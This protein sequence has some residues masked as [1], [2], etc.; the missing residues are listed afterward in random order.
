MQRARTSNPAAG[1]FNPYSAG[2]CSGSDWSD[3]K[4]DR[5]H[6]VSIL[7][8]LE[9]ALEVSYQYDIATQQLRFNPYSAGNCSGSFPFTKA[10]QHFTRVSILILLE[11]ALE[12]FGEKL[13]RFASACFNPYSA[14]NC[15]GSSVNQMGY[16]EG[17]GCFNPYSA[18]NCSGSRQFRDF[19]KAQFEFQSLFCWKLL[20][21]CRASLR[22]Y[23]Y[24]KVSILILLEIALEAKV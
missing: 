1:S 21:K 8:L 23:H 10:F 7:I 24:S 22:L 2:N 20:W 12:V 6:F 14:G 16:E 3:K 19:Q 18:G 4:R 13:D 11:I 5:P 17:I 15:S 9:I